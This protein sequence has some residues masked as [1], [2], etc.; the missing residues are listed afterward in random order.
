MRNVTVSPGCAEPAME[1]C[2]IT[3]GRSMTM[4]LVG[5]GE[6]VGVGDGVGVGVFVGVGVGVGQGTVSVAVASVTPFARFSTLTT[7]WPAV[8]M[9]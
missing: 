3:T 1:V 6:A 9:V 7:Y 5:M 8:G 2:P 4:S